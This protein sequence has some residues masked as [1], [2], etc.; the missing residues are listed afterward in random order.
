MSAP[1]PAR[2]KKRKTDDEKTAQQAA[3]IEATVSGCNTSLLAKHVQL[4]VPLFV[5]YAQRDH[6]EIEGKLGKF[7]TGQS[8]SGSGRVAKTKFESGV[9]REDF[10]KYH[11]MLSSFK[12]WDPASKTTHWTSI[13]DY[14]LDGNIRVSKTSAGNCFVRKTLLEN[15]NLHCRGRSYDMRISL[16]EELPMQVR[17]PQEPRLVR[18]KKRKSFIYQGEWQFDITI[19]WTGRDEQDAASQTPTYEIE[20]EYMKPRNLLLQGHVVDYAYLAGSMLEKMIDFLGRETPFQIE[21]IN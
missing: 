12:G 11:D 15:V 14:I 18:V 8:G 9:S 4:V 17:L 7:F 2:I 21:A 5:K 1:P 10:N 20:C 3:A 16:K 13:F 19:A 6:L